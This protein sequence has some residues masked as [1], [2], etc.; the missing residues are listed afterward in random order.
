ML[1]T[2]QSIIP[3][4]K[5]FLSLLNMNVCS[6]HILDFLNQVQTLQRLELF[7]Q[8]ISHCFALVTFLTLLNAL[9]VKTDFSFLH[10]VTG[11]VVTGAIVVGGL[12]ILNYVYCLVKIIW[13]CTC[14]LVWKIKKI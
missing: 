9:M 2:I 12:A 13:K 8:I 14:G 10:P 1:G 5:A 3:E 7:L 6:T 11:A 4:E